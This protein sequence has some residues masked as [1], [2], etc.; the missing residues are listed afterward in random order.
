MILSVLLGLGWVPVA[1]VAGGLLLAWTLQDIRV[2]FL[3]VVLLASFVN[4]RAGR[5]TLETDWTVFAS[6]AWNE[7]IPGDPMRFRDEVDLD[8]APAWVLSRQLS[9][10][11][12]R[13]G[14][15]REIVR[16]LGGSFEET[17]MGAFSVFHGFR[18]PYDESRAVPAAAIQVA[19]AAGV[20]VGREV[21]D[22]DP[23][24]AWTSPEGLSRGS[25]L[26]VRVAPARRLSALV[27]LVDLVDSPLAVPWAASVAGEVVAEGPARSG[28]QWVNGAPRAARQALLVVSLGDREA[29]EV[30]LAFQGP[31]PRLAVYE[32]FL[33][34][35]G[36]EAR[37][38]DGAHR[39]FD[40]RAQAELRDRDR[41]A[42]DAAGRARV[43]AHGVLS[44]G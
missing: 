28:F 11:M 23:A 41:H 3:T 15:F 36:E 10:G 29:D 38:G 9:R 44:L 22:R 16:G 4:Y 31:G 1:L 37:P 7:R 20:A 6:Q 13:A 34:G 32:L 24:T 17:E 2:G 5:L 27:L 8:P 42:F 30:R 14:G 40:R 33:Y 25:G 18:P 21:L 12:P 19:T 43:A 35:P 26:V 39:G